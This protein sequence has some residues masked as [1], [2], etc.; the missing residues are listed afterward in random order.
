[1]WATG[2]RGSAW[3]ELLTVGHA[4]A[5][6][7]AFGDKNNGYLAID[8]FA[9]E[10]AGWVLHTSDG[11]ASWRPQLI[12]RSPIAST[13]G[14]L[15][16]AQGGVAHTLVSTSDLFSTGNGGD[17]AESSTLTLS[18]KTRRLRRKG[19]VRIDG[20]LAPAAPG[21]R[22]EIDM[23]QFNSARWVRSIATVRSDGTFSA[24][25]TVSRTSS[26]VAQWAGDQARNGDGSTALRVTVGSR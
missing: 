15:V 22:V 24:N 21:A 5:Y 2:N 12:S 20:K 11:G 4:D 10:T 8:S 6:E 3:R 23:R 9:G 14:S 25:F 17:A 1:V 26:F 18:T 7:L 16:A 13:L 19:K